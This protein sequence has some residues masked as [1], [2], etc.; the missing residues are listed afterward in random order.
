M[1][2]KKKDKRKQAFRKPDMIK[3][4]KGTSN[5]QINISFRSN[6]KAFQN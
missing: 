6:D 1:R 5:N 4:V 3:Q 2:K